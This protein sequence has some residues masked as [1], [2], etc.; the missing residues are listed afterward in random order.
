MAIRIRF[1]A[2]TATLRAV[3]EPETPIPANLIKNTE[4]FAWMRRPFRSS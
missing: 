3:S 2:L 4:Q 1:K